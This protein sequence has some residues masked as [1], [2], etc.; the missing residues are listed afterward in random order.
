MIR[1]NS[2]RVI[3]L[4]GVLVVALQAGPVRAE[5]G[6]T[7]AGVGTAAAVSSLIYGPVKIVYAVLGVVFGGFAWG[8]SGGDSEVMTAVISPAVRGDYVVTPSHIRGEKSL[9]F[10]GQRPDYY[11]DTVV[12]EE[13]Y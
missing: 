1:L 6:A 5:D 12:L 13:V 4:L 7:E 10:F 11:E 9:E 8:L 2:I 3:A